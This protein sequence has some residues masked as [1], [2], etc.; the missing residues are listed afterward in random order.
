MTRKAI[1]WLVE[2]PRTP[3]FS[4]TVRR[5]AGYLLARLQD[6]ETIGMPHSRP[7]PAVAP[8]LHELRLRDPEAQATWRIIY[9]A[10]AD[11][12]V[13]VHIYDKD[14]NRMPTRVQRVCRDRVRDY[15]RRAR[16][17]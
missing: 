3:P 17:R 8:R 10:D 5:L 1:H 16:R 11:R 15:D 4:E 2:T 6:G 14:D 12:V 13:V 9:R 7:I